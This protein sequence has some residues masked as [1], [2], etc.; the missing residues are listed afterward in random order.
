M[1]I[2]ADEGVDSPIVSRLRVLGHDVD[3]I[4]EI[5]PGISD[6]EVLKIAL[7]DSRIL[8]TIDKDFG[9]LVFRL[10]QTHAGVILIR[11]EGLKGMEKAAIMETAFITYGEA[12]LN[13]FTVIQK[14][15]IRI[16]K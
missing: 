14:N 2:L 4:S 12:F 13:S 10:K 7:N 16:R 11:L 15:Y 9:E 6:E 1:K 5:D 8:L 3:Y